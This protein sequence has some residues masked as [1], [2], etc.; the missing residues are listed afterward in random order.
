M[1]PL[2]THWPRGFSLACP[3]GCLTSPSWTIGRPVPGRCEPKASAVCPL[4]R[5]T[6][7]I[8]IDG[9]CTLILGILRNVEHLA[10]LPINNLVLVAFLLQSPLL[11]IVFAVLLGS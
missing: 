3:Y 5:P 8:W 11:R 1:N 9:S 7:S 6:V 2:S 4:P 10:A